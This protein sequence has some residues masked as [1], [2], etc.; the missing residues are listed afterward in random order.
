MPSSRASSKHVTVWGP[1]G[2]PE[3]RAPDVP[4]GRGGHGG[5]FGGAHQPYSR[6]K[7]L[8]SERRWTVSLPTGSLESVMRS[9]GVSST[10]NGGVVVV[11]GGEVS[12][13]R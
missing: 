7:L 9:K 12:E 1:L 3:E 4:R 2:A 11:V 8:R 13:K 6:P 10:S 5:A